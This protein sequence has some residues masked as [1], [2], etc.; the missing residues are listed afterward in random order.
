[1]DRGEL[2]ALEPRL[3]DAHLFFRE[4]RVGFW[5]SRISHVRITKMNRGMKIIRYVCAR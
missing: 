1:M 3:D 4:P 5:E 2:G